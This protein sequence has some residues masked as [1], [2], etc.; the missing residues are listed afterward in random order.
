MTKPLEGQFI[1]NPPIL[2][3]RTKDSYNCEHIRFLEYI[4]I[5]GT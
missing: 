1:C 3:K 5:G 2:V 4:S